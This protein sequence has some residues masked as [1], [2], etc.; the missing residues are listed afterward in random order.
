V[1]ADIAGPFRIS[2]IP[3]CQFTTA[4]SDKA[5][6]D[7]GIFRGFLFDLVTA[8]QSGTHSTG[9]AGRNLNGRPEPV[10]TNLTMK[11]GEVSVEEMISSVESGLM[12][13]DILSGEGSNA[14]SGDFAFDSCNVL[15]IE[16]GEVTGRIPGPLLRGNV[17]EMLRRVTGVGDRP[18]RTGSDLFPAVLAGG[19]TLCSH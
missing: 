3:F 1:N 10:C 12:V 13:T 19:I 14:V 9:N 8:A 16:G 2:G 5:I 15:A 4:T 6:F 18:A 17:Y 7:R 11:P